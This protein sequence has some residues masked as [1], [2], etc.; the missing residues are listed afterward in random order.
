MP[1]PLAIV[2]HDR[3]GGRMKR[4]AIVLDEIFSRGGASLQAGPG[5]SQVLAPNSR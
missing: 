5:Q 1:L 4:G 2:V 3:T